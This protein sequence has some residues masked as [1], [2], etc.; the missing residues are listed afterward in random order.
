MKISNETKAVS[1]LISDTFRLSAALWRP[2]LPFV[3]GCWATILIINILL[4]SIPIPFLDVNAAPWLLKFYVILVYT[5][6]FSAAFVRADSRLQGSDIDVRA[7]FSKT[8]SRFGHLLLGLI[9]YA[10]F[11]AAL[12]VVLIGLNYP[13]VYVR[14]IPGST[15]LTVPINIAAG[16]LGL[17]MAFRGYFMMPLI[18]SRNFSALSAYQQSWR[19]SK[20]NCFRIFLLSLICIIVPSEMFK[21]IASVF[22]L[23]AKP[24]FINFSLSIYFLFLIFG[25]MIT[26]VLGSATVYTLLN[27]CELAQSDM[28]TAGHA[29]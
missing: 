21:E 4:N 7:A 29:T 23:Q 20:G 9:I 22:S 17:Y 16:V 25:F 15:Q 26:I 12:I 13:S 10:T 28:S 2:L 24:T 11:L 8:Y 1:E 3:L 19:L 27:Q 18:A 6:Y 5:L 14:Y